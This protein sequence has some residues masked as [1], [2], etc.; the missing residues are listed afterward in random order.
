MIIL[1]LIKQ[2]KLGEVTT[3]TRNRLDPEHVESIL[4]IQQNKHVDQIVV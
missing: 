1:F 4:L 2:L 3:A